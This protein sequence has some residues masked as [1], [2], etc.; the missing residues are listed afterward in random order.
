METVTGPSS[1]S[2]ATTRTAA[3]SRKIRQYNDNGDRNDRDN[4]IRPPFRVG[5]RI[6]SPRP[7]AAGPVLP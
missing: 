3:L 2:T 1:R 6:H 4:D 5:S 7:P